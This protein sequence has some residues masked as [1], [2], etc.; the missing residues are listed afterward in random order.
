MVTQYVA[1]DVFNAPA[2]VW[3]SGT[4]SDVQFYQTLL[5]AMNNAGT[6]QVLLPE[7]CPV[8]YAS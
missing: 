5:D 1:I 7:P 4:A 8:S 6:V 2:T 3:L